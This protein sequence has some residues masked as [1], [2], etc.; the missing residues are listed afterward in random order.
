MCDCERGEGRR[1]IWIGDRREVVLYMPLAFR[2]GEWE[3]L[4]FVELFLQ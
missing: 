3:V 1:N 4:C 2:A